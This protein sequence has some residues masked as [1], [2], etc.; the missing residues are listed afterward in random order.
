MWFETKLPNRVMYHKKISK[1]HYRKLS[2]CVRCV[3][4]RGN[5]REMKDVVH[6]FPEIQWQN[7]Y[8]EAV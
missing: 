1:L 4:E 8:K 6:V 2:T 3:H 7:V 5:D